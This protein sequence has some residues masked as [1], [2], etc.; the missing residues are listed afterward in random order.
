MAMGRDPAI[1]A[2]SAA[3]VPQAVRWKPNAHAIGN[4]DAQDWFCSKECWELFWDTHDHWQ[5]V[6]GHLVRSRSEDTDF[7][8]DKMDAWWEQYEVGWW[9]LSRYRGVRRGGTKWSVARWHEFKCEVGRAIARAGEVEGLL[10]SSR[11]CSTPRLSPA[12]TPV[13]AP[14]TH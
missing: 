8:A 14:A 11:R 4:D 6:I 13:A 9:Q 3:A 10:E 7:W 2:V 12:A 5:E 1:G